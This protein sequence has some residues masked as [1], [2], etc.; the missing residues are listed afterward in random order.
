MS[1]EVLS[2]IGVIIGLALFVYMMFKGV[3]VFITVMLAG[4]LVA[5]F[6][7][8]NVY[9]SLTTT[10][11]GGFA[12]YLTNM[13]A[14]FVMG[15]IFGK[16]IGMTG[17]ADAIAAKMLKIFGK[18][19]VEIVLTLVTGLGIGLISNGIFDITWVQVAI[20]T[21]EDWLK[22]LVHKENKEEVTE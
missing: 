6:G 4:T 14:T 18:K 10:F 3:N 13:M 16:V 20:Q 1:P 17:C 15:G 9:T 2:L 5:I 21:I 22:K 19:H 12:G 11:I 7:G 8:M